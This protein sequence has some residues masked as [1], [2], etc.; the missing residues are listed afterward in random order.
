MGWGVGREESARE[1]VTP[2]CP[3]LSLASPGT[4]PP[5]QVP[6]SLF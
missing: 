6:P 2:A 5:A 4:P 3:R 1:A